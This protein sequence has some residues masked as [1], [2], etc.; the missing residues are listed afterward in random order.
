MSSVSEGREERKKGSLSVNMGGISLNP[1]QACVNSLGGSISENLI[2]LSKNIQLEGGLE[3]DVNAGLSNC[4]ACVISMVTLC[5]WQRL[6]RNG[7]EV[8]AGAG[9]RRKIRKK[10]KRD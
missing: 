8:K 9:E 2:S 1:S 3:W 4:K 10:G 6:P 7:K 5:F